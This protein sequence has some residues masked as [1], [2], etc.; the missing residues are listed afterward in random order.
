MEWWIASG[1]R[2]SV[3]RGMG[4]AASRVTATRGHGLRVRCG[5]ARGEARGEGG[6]M[7]V[8]LTHGEVKKP[9]VALYILLVE[10]GYVVVILTHDS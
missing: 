4:E 3:T 9:R 5:A 10:L 6:S 1:G 7:V 8:I 2:R